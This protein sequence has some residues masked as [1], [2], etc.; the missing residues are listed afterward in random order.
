MRKKTNNKGFTL[1]ELVIVLA[2]A[3]LILVGILLAVSGAQRS[4]RDQQRKSD[5]G[6][7]L[8]NVETL[9][10]NQ[11][12]VVP[13]S[14]SA[15]QFS[16]VTTGMTDPSSG[17][18]YTLVTTTPAAVGAVQYIQGGGS[19]KACDGTSATT[20]RNVVLY[21]GLESGGNACVDDH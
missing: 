15:A 19:Q 17:S 21:M 12:G 9:E 1:I 5:L 18:A 2:I 4:R 20:A 16:Q 7:I 11:G 10:S 3:A 14:L 8:A 6:R 13:S